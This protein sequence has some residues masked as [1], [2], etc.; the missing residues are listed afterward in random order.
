MLWFPSSSPSPVLPALS[1]Y[2]FIQ[3][4]PLTFLKFLHIPKQLPT[5]SLLHFLPLQCL[6]FYLLSIR[7]EVILIPTFLR[8][9]LGDRGMKSANLESHCFL[10]LPLIPPS[11]DTLWTIPLLEIVFGKSL[12]WVHYHKVNLRG[13]LKW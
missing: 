10:L 8:I 4:S 7:L 5:C 6:S 3:S 12:S 1:L 2:S 11:L 13:P 9:P